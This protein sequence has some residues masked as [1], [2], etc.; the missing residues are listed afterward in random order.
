MAIR[1]PYTLEENSKRISQVWNSDAREIALS[2]QID[3]TSY[4]EADFTTPT[5]TNVGNINP[6]SIYQMADGSGY[7][8]GFITYIGVPSLT[9]TFT[10]LDLD[11]VLELQSVLNKYAIGGC[12]VPLPRVVSGATDNTSWLLAIGFGAAQFTRIEAQANVGATSTLDTNDRLYL[13]LPLLPFDRS[14]T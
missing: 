13:H 2:N 6:L 9:A 14:R 5:A 8:Q 11:G 4:L 1:P 3:L 12:R 7:I 10:I